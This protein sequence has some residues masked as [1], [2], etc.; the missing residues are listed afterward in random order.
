MS[1]TFETPSIDTETATF[2][3]LQDFKAKATIFL[4]TH[5]KLPLS[6]LLSPSTRLELQADD[7]DPATIKLD[8]FIAWVEQRLMPDDVLQLTKD[9]AA[10][11]A[12]TATP[13]PHALLSITRQHAAT[14]RT[15]LQ[16]FDKLADDDDLLQDLPEDSTPG[17]NFSRY[18]GKCF[19]KGLGKK[20]R[21]LW[22]LD[23]DPGLSLFPVVLELS[24]PGYCLFPVANW[25]AA[26]ALGFRCYCLRGKPIPIAPEALRP[27]P[28]KYA[29]LSP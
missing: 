27:S 26:F 16:L 22:C 8:A 28:C 3:S 12:P 9:L 23:S 7:H 21:N 15:R 1:L 19:V 25:S 18:A 4:D 20:E 29:F 11:K 13:G 6:I 5:K 2:E 10:L 24:A 17:D 14:V